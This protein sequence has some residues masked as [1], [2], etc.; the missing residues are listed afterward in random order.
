MIWSDAGYAASGIDGENLRVIGEYI[1][2]GGRLTISSRMPFLALAPRRPRPSAT[3][4]SPVKCPNWSR[5]CPQ[6]RCSL[7]AET[8]L[9]S[10]LEGNAD[11]EAGARS[12]L[13]RGPVSADQGAPVLILMS[14]AGFDDPKVARLLLFGVSMGWLPAY[15]ATELIRNMAD[16]MLAE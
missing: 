7:I 15:Q 9:L 14:D 12:A 1:D 4:R 13:V 8:P 10:P 2:G 16:V 11:P 5:G 6:R 3:S